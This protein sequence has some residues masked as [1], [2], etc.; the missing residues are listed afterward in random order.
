MLEKKTL[1]KSIVQLILIIDDI[2]SSNMQSRAIDFV[3]MMQMIMHNVFYHWYCNYHCLHIH[4]KLQQLIQLHIH[5]K[6]Q[7]MI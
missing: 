2:E 4:H 6:S 5:Y 7:Q 3:M 1:S